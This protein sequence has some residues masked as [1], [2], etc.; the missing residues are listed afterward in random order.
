[1]LHLALAN[2][3]LNGYAELKMHTAGPTDALI[4]RQK[5]DRF[6]VDS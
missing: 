6:A 3:I 1:M 5:L 4:F 2:C